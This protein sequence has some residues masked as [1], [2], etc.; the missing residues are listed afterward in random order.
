RARLCPLGRQSAA[1]LLIAAGLLRLPAAALSLLLLLPALAP[2]QSQS[3]SWSQAT[4]GTY[5]WSTA[6]NWQG[7]TVANGAD[8]TA[9]FATS[10]LT[11]PIT[12]TLDTS[13]TI[14]SLV[15]DNPTN[16]F[17]WTLRS[18]GS[19]TLTLSSSTGPVIAVNNANILVDVPAALVGTQ[20]FTKTGAG[21][22][23]LTNNNSGLAGGI[24]VSQGVLVASGSST[25]NP[26]GTG[27][28]TLAG[29]T[30]RLGSGGGFNQKMVVPVQ[31][32]NANGATAW[33]NA[34]NAGAITA[35]MDGGT[36]LGGNTWYELGTNT[37]ATTT[38][39]PMG[40]T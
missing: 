23:S 20:G 27:A 31:Y 25:I 12:V 11:G 18:S 13:R 17:G 15:Y 8:A 24:T 32:A 38:G 3:G 22:L 5:D 30:L 39:L 14:G 10:N 9:T 7:G 2:A 35:S 33:T 34:L 21:T 40:T 37:G 36:T 28:V 19:T 29:G 1:C 6:T 16:T 26:L 4:S